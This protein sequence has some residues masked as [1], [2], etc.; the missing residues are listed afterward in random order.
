[1]KYLRTK[2]QFN[3]LLAQHTAMLIIFVDPNEFMPA[4]LLLNYF[5]SHG[6]KDHFDHLVFIWN[7]VDQQIY[8]RYSVAAF[9]QMT[10]VKGNEVVFSAVGYNREKANIAVELLCQAAGLGTLKKQIN[11]GLTH[12][13]GGHLLSPLDSTGESIYVNGCFECNRCQRLC[14]FEKSRPT[15]HCA[16]CSYDVCPVCS[17]SDVLIK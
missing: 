1:M 6:A 13:P 17:Y 16:Y 15:L 4:K 11:K 3:N 2:E 8:D 10:V 9:P 7:L 5:F 14:H 12:C